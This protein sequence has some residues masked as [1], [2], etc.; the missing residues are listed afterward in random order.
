MALLSPMLKNFLLVL[1][2]IDA[3]DV[4]SPGKSKM[5][6]AVTT[7]VATAAVAVSGPVAYGPT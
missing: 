4:K 5:K 3:V 6:A 2:N 1:V 7:A